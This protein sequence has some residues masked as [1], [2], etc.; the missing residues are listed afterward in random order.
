MV[1]QP[2]GRPNGVVAAGAPRPNVLAPG[3]V[4]VCASTKEAHSRIS[5]IRPYQS[6]ALGRNERWMLRFKSTA[7]LRLAQLLTRVV[8]GREPR[9]TALICILRAVFMATV[10]LRALPGMRSD[11]LTD[12]AGPPV[13]RTVRPAPTVLSSATL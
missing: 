10:C 7:S 1:F 13:A 4:A 11:H 8:A 5:A 6:Q 12:S 9:T 2:L 3:V